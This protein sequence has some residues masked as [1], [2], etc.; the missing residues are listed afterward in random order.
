MFCI[1]MSVLSLTGRLVKTFHMSDVAKICLFE[2]N[3]S[4][5]SLV[6]LTLYLLTM[7][8]RK[9]WLKDLGK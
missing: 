6:E 7:Y 4:R 3:I 5:N 9:S 2:Y 8:G 1:T